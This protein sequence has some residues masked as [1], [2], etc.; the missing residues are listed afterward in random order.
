[1]GQESKGI[2]EIS[3]TMSCE[4]SFDIN[5]SKT[6]SRIFIFCFV[7]ML[8]NISCVQMSKVGS[9]RLYCSPP[10]ILNQ[11]LQLNSGFIDWLRFM[12]T[13]VRDPP[14]PFKAVLTDTQHCMQLYPS[15]READSGSCAFVE[16]LPIE[17]SL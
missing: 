7:C 13:E 16:H 5:I 15:A 10:Y 17:I 14:S 1:M 9:R 2:E 11:G 3:Q 8:V 12:V 6:L 4:R